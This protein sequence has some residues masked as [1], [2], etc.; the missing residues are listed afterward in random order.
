LKD[1]TSQTKAQF[2]GSIGTI[3]DLPTLPVVVQKILETCNDPLSTVGDLEKI[4]LTDQALTT[5]ILRLV[6]S[7]YFALPQKVSSVSRAITFLGFN[8]VKSLAL[9]LTLTNIFHE[10]EGTGELDYEK[11]WTHSLGT[12]IAAKQIAKTIMYPSPEEGFIAGMLHDVGKLVQVKFFPDQYAGTIRT[13][14]TTGRP[15]WTVEKE[16]HD[17]THNFVGAVLL[18]HWNFPR[19]IQFAVRYHHEVHLSSEFGVF[20][21]LIHL[22]DHLCHRWGVSDLS[23]IPHPDLHTD[24]HAFIEKYNLEIDG[25]LRTRVLDGI[26][27]IKIYLGIERY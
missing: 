3:E 27:E 10:I 1:N 5:K 6:N 8:A 24:G 12:A 7:A 4:F 17:F 22:A 9:S 14:S 2:I 13:A 19:L 20:I 21:S 23:G 16:S 15:F 25:P 26:K 11:F 18:E